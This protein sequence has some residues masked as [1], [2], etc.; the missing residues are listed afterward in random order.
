MKKKII[1]FH[2]ALA[3]YRIDFFNKLAENFRTSFYF[4]HRNVHDQKFNQKLLIS[5]CSFKINY[6]KKGFDIFNRSVRV[7]V[8]SIIND[9]NPDIVLCSEY[10]FVTILSFLHNF[11]H[12]KKYR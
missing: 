2:P 5:K 3:P 9:E 4:Y 10:G 1:V 12:K 11:I 7:E 6:L 8:I